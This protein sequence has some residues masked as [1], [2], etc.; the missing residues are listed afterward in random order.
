MKHTQMGVWD[1]D[2]SSKNYFHGRYA[3]N[4][5]EDVFNDNELLIKTK[6]KYLSCCFI[7]IGTVIF[8]I[9]A[10]NRKKNIL[11]LRVGGFGS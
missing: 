7:H 2:H 10:K 5:R 9:R 4:S 3:K 1:R 6:Q 11:Y 8:K